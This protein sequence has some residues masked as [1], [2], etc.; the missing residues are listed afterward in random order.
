MLIWILKILKYQNLM[1]LLSTLNY[2]NHVVFQ[3]SS[4][5]QFI[6][7]VTALNSTEI[8]VYVT[9]EYTKYLT[10][11]IRILQDTNLIEQFI[12]TA[13]SIYDDNTAYI[14]WSRNETLKNFRHLQMSGN[15]VKKSIQLDEYVIIYIKGGVNT[16]GMFRLLITS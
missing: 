4:P 16:D 2:S 11:I 14:I 13:T 5:V 6:Q 7:K 8:E 3:E 9:N 12:S 1:I 15:M 10:E